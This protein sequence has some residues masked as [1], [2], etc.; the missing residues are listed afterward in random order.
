MGD[1]SGQS[2]PLAG[3]GNP[4]EV[5]DINNDGKLDISDGFSD[6]AVNQTVVP[7]DL[8]EA[9]EKSC[10]PSWLWGLEPACSQSGIDET[11]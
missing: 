5:A 3:I 7:T 6:W 1:R 10:C 4:P 2:G 8:P 9:P 11:D